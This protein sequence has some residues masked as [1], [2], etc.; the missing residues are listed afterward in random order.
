MSLVEVSPNPLSIII[1]RDNN[2]KKISQ[3]ILK[4]ITN[5]YILY[6]F[7]INT[8]GVLLARPPTS[9]IK[10]SQSV[11]IEVHVLNNDLPLEDY[12]N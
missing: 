2:E 3:I 9:F 8:K 1:S 12:N 4:N 5:Q 10:P 7:L 11:S 6:K